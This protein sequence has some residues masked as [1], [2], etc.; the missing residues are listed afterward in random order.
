MMELAADDSEPGYAY[1]VYIY[2]QPEDY[3]NM[4]SSALWRLAHGGRLSAP[5]SPRA[6]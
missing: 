5:S 3:Q 4:S 6:C 2:F 1:W